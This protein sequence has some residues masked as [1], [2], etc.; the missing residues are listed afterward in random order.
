MS[1]HLLLDTHSQARFA[2]AWHSTKINAIALLQ[3]LGEHTSENN[4][5]RL[6]VIWIA[7]IGLE[8]PGIHAR[9]NIRSAKNAIPQREQFFHFSSPQYWR[10]A[11][12]ARYT[13]IASKP[14][15]LP[16]PTIGIFLDLFF[17]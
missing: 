12:W 2:D 4:L 1:F 15:W 6:N 11:F 3:L 10:R 9:W 17:A 5:A 14:N 8:C 7:C 16:E 13:G